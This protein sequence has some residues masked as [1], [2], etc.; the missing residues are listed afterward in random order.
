M[1]GANG[2]SPL[3]GFGNDVRSSNRKSAVRSNPD[4]YYSLRHCDWNGVEGSNLRAP[5]RLLPI[6]AMTTAQPDFA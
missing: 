5:R 6:V 1:V 4:N 3:Q 2:H